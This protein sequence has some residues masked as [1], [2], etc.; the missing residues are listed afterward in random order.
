MSM[1]DPPPSY[2]GGLRRSKSDRAHRRPK[3]RK[4]VADTIDRLDT[5]PFGGPYHH[6]GPYDATMKSFNLNSKFSPVA[7]VRES[8]RAAWKATPREAKLDAL[9]RGRP[10]DATASVPPGER[11]LNGELMDYEYSTDMLRDPLAGGGPYRRWPG[12]EYHPDDLKGKGEP[13]FTLDRERRAKEAISRSQ[14]VR[15]RPGEYELVPQ[16]P[17]GGSDMSKE[18]GQPAILVRQRSS[19]ASASS[20]RPRDFVDGLKRRVGSL[21]RR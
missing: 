6:G 13:G 7:A 3:P 5:S 10:L 16:R 2:D 17:H 15:E 11:A 1:R 14:S 20:S 8:N 18:S 12:V 19:S 9:L 4:Y 21:R